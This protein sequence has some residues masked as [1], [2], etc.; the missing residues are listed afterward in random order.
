MEIKLTRG[1]AC[2]II[3]TGSLLACA[4]SAQFE[5]ISHWEKNNQQ[6]IFV[7]YT[8]VT[9]LDSL[10]EYA[11]TKPYVDGQNTT[12]CF[13]N[14]KK[15]APDISNLNA[16]SWSQAVIIIRDSEPYKHCTAWYDRLS[17]G[18]ERIVEDPAI[19]LADALF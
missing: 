10:Q 12:V 6:Y 16:N 2:F 7:V 14:D 3:I 9:N 8:T 1:L 18:D 17:S 11:E 13:Y 19:H 4:K 5:D 15:I